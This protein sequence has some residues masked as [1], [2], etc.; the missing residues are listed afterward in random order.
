MTRSPLAWSCVLPLCLCAALTAP[1]AART[2]ASCTTTAGPPVKGQQIDIRESTNGI[3]VACLATLLGQGD[4]QGE[5][6]TAPG[7]LRDTALA[8]FPGGGDT[9]ARARS[10]WFDRLV[11]GAPVAAL[12]GRP[13]RLLFEWGVDGR[14]KTT[15]DGRASFGARLQGGPTNRGWSLLDQV[16]GSLNSPNDVSINHQRRGAALSFVFDEPAEFF[17]ELDVTARSASNAVLGGTARAQFG[18]TAWWGGVTRV[19]DEF[20]NPL[21]VQV[22]TLGGIDLMH[23][24]KPAPVPEPATAVLTAVGAAWLLLRRRIGPRARQPAR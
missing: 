14:L 15:G 22:T 13:G 19:E 4:A 1:V 20:G 12:S 17:F 10:E 18:S 16:L 3:P 24:F 11:I 8:G 7:V 5:S 6:S 9:F 21:D 23:S 2:L